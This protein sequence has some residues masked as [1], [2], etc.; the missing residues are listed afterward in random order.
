M[1]GTLSP[2]L[3]TTH[4]V[5]PDKLPSNPCWLWPVWLSKPFSQQQ[6]SLYTARLAHV[7]AAAMANAEQQQQPLRNT[8]LAV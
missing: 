4:H 3:T 1:M 8:H 2:D 5:T 6:L 7:A